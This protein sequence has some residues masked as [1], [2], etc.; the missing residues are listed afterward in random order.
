MYNPGLDP[1]DPDYAFPE[2]V[3][4]TLPTQQP[5]LGTRAT[6]RDP[7]TQIQGY[8]D[9]EGAPAESS[10]G[11][12]DIYGADSA[13]ADPSA[14][15]DLVQNALTA[16]GTRT[17]HG[18]EDPVGFQELER[19]ERE[20]M[21]EFSAPGNTLR[22]NTANAMSAALAAQ[23]GSSTIND[24]SNGGSSDN[25]HAGN[26]T[27][28][29]QPPVAHGAGLPGPM[30]TARSAPVTTATSPQPGD[31]ED[32]D[33]LWETADEKNGRQG[34][35]A[36]AGRDLAAVGRSGSIA[37]SGVA[38]LGA[39]GAGMG[40]AA[41]RINSAP[42]GSPDALR[43]RAGT[44]VNPRASRIMA[45]PGMSSVSTGVAARPRNGMPP[46]PA[47]GSATLVRRRGRK[48]SRCCCLS[49]RIS[50]ASQR[51]QRKCF[52]WRL[53]EDY[54]RAHTVYIVYRGI[55]CRAN[56]SCCCD[57]MLVACGLLCG[58]VVSV[59]D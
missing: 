40:A 58:A 47:S 41:R 26:A 48:Q 19:E 43:T 25:L 8:E 55:E 2:E 23:A 14:L 17:E 37:A 21:D 10:A 13:A 9:I 15:A 34:P 45:L 57:C 39:G 33:F 3:A 28:L 51:L 31:D 24:S 18:E 7:D 44:G 1:D 36:A 6:T 54:V 32:Y 46:P 53:W 5:V 35:P 42:V 12:E 59:A 30:P 38:G 29:P 4:D 27:T 49:H 56:V 11:Y 16:G 22:R 20:W 50:A 52:S